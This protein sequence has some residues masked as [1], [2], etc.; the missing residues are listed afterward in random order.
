MTFVRALLLAACVGLCLQSTAGRAHEGHDDAAP[1]A[2]GLPGADVPRIEAQSDLFEVVGVLRNGAMT[3]FVD[4]YATNEPVVDAKIDVEAGT[5]KGSAQAGADGTYSFSSPAFAQPG[6]LPVTLT[7]VA[8]SDSDLL[9][10]NLVI[11]GAADVAGHARAEAWWM[12]WWWGAGAL[13]LVAGIAVA[14]WSRRQR[15]EGVAR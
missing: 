2:P 10:G 7:I 5:A 8:G 14:W 11:A 15:V 4:R 12:R 9:T 3:L 6:Q 13:L 1:P